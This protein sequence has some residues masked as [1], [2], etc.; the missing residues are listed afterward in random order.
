MKKQ[1]TLLL[2][3][4]LAS[5]I[6]GCGDDSSFSPGGGISSSNI[7]SKVKFTIASDNL[8]PEFIKVT[9][10]PGTP[11]T[12]ID[13]IDSFTVGGAL[14][15]SAFGADRFGAKTSGN[16]ITFVSNYGSIESS[17]TLDIDGSCSSTLTSLGDLPPISTASIAGTT[18]EIIAANIVIYTLGEESFFDANGNGFFDDGDIFNTAT[19]DTDEPY[20]DNN[21]NNTFDAGTDEPIDIDGN[22]AY[23][24]ADGLYSGSNCQHSSLCSPSPSIIIWD[25]VQIDLITAGG[26]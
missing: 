10:L 1:L 25:D 9:Y 8:N 2:L 26:G 23:T 20:L 19:D 13:T 5:L 12:T 15:I 24:P 14:V 21:N 11:P 7:I 3:T 22:G 18:T 4:F 17:C 6:L 16:N